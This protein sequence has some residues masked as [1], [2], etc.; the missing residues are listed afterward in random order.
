MSWMW[1]LPIMF[2]LM[3]LNMR[4]YLAMFSA[5]VIYFLFFNNLPFGI[6]VQR[7][8]AP[9]QNSTLLAIP[10][11]ILLGTLLS[12]TGVAERI[13]RSE[14]HTSELQSREHLVCRLLLEKE[15]HILH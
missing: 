6:A 12:H 3:L 7:L 13:L 8:V 9:A 5:I 4:I 14:E 10:F 11:F 2:G 1:I 15:K